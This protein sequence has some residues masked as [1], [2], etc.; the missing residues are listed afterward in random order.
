MS[1]G[2]C[3]DEPCQC[4]GQIW[5][6][7][8]FTRSWDNSECLK[9]LGSPWI[10]RS[11]SSKVID[12]GTN[13]KP[14]CD[15]LL[16]R[17]SNLGP[18]LHHFGDIAGF[19]CSWVTHPYSTLILGVLP[20]HQIAQVGISPSRSLKLFGRKLFSKYSNLCEKHTLTSRTDRQTAGR[21]DGRTTYCVASRGKNRKTA[22]DRCASCFYFY[23]VSV[24]CRSLSPLSVR[25]R[26]ANS[27]STTDRYNADA[28]I[29]Q[30]YRCAN[31]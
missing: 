13:R 26:H 11:R 22:Y 12:F 29:G 21:T 24:S 5:S 19:L 1:L 20:L 31:L 25:C 8:S 4:T 7:Y 18:I 2:F 9:T 27:G 16:A 30:T 10:R 28:D 15:F 17:H 3:S 14:V 23:R 6:P